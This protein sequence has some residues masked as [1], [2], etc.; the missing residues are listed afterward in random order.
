[1]PIKSMH[2]YHSGQQWDSINQVLVGPVPD[3]ATLLPLTLDGFIYCG[4]GNNLMNAIG[5]LQL[6]EGIAD[7]LFY[8]DSAN[9]A[10]IIACYTGVDY[11]RIVTSDVATIAHNYPPTIIQD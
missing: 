8:Y 2:V 4:M 9:E 10:A 11:Y 3:Y 7:D 1:M 6:P 5:W